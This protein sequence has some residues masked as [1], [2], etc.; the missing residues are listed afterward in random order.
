M[1]KI[2]LTQ[3]KFAIVDDEDFHYLSRF[4]WRI[5]NG[6]SKQPNNTIYA[7][8]SLMFKS[9]DGVQIGRKKDRWIYMHEEIVP[10]KQNLL[11]HHK[12]GDTLDNRKE[13]LIYISRTGADHRLKKKPNCSSNYKGVW[14]NKR[15]KTW[16]A[17]IDCNH[18]KYYLGTFH[19]EKEAAE[20]YNK[21]ARELYGEFAYQNKID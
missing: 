20:V 11:T 19:T 7:A 17:Q 12:N 15:G 2:P 21:K 8:R 13:N 5:W 3:G 14:F 9:P 4:K 10:T 1:K 18:I 6:S 16:G